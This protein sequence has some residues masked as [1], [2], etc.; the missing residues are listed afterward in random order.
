[1]GFLIKSTG[2]GRCSKLGQVAMVDTQTRD[3]LDR[4]VAAG[5]PGVKEAR[6][7]E[8]FGD[9]EDEARTRAIREC[10]REEIRWRAA[11]KSWKDC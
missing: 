10:Y 9:I 5:R 11:A 8:S 4:L 2:H 6:T 7:G 3:R 1:L